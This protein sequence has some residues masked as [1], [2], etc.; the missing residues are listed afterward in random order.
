MNDLTPEEP[1]PDRLIIFVGILSVWVLSLL[2]PPF[3]FLTVGYEN[4]PEYL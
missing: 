2:P 4:H 3:G 1:R